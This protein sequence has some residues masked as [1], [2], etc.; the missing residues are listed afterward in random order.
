[1]AEIGDERCGELASRRFQVMTSMRTL[2]VGDSQVGLVG[3][4]RMGLPV[5]AALV[6][7]GYQVTATDRRAE[8][9]S[10]ALACGAAWRDTPAQAAAGRD[11]LITM[12]PGSREVWVAMLGAA[13]ALE[14]MSAGATWIDMTSNS[15]TAV[16]PVRERAIEAGVQVLEAPVGG[17]I[18]AARERRLQLFVGGDAGLVERHRALLEAM[19]DPERIVYVGDHGTGYTAKLLVN[20][21]WF[22]QAV[23]TAEA[24]LLGQRAGIDLRVLEQALRGSS[25]ASTFN[26]RDVAALFHGDYLASFGLDRI[27]EELEAVTVLAHDYRVPFELSDL[28]CRTYRRALARYGPVNGELLAMALIEDE[29]GQKLR[30]RQS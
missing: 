29:A 27:C 9:Q 21:L 4:G 14:G 2:P 13:G 12:L 16:R 30:T 19:G 23:A 7:A 26:R 17:G 18:Q 28:V 25:A 22:G 11:V 1:L 8:S 3:L 5:C 20:L 24:L 6:D 10:D 15:P